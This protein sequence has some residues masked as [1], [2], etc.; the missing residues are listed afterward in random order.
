MKR[1]NQKPRKAYQ[2]HKKSSTTAA[3]DSESES[4]AELDLEAWDSWFSEGV[5]VESTQD[6]LD[7]DSI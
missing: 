3:S 1:V 4:E 2:K 6:S 5:C 7:L